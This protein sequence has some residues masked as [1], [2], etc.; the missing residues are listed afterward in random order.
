[1]VVADA[2]QRARVIWQCCRDR[3]CPGCQGRRGAEVAAKVSTLISRWPSCRMITLTKKHTGQTLPTMIDELAEAFKAL[4]RTE[5]WKSAVRGGVYVYEV[6]RGA[7]GDAWHAH[8][9][10]LVTGGFVAQK[11]LSEA[12]LSCTGDS[13]I[14]HIKYVHNRESGASY[15][16]RYLG[17]PTGLES[18]DAEEIVEYAVAVHRRRL[19]HTF[20]CVHRAGQTP[21]DEAQGAKAVE[22]V[23]SVADLQRAGEGG[24]AEAAW[25]FERLRLAFLLPHKERAQVSDDDLKRV[26]SIGRRVYGVVHELPG[27]D[28]ATPAPPEV[29]KP[30]PPRAPPLLFE[31]AHDA[32]RLS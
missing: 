8:V 32:R 19:I 9:H 24:D 18:W 6:T 26:A 21:I 3:L 20:G 11:A 30:R 23:C 31:D 12:W 15:V 5:L 4:R 16:A 29:P 7:K 28:D 14:V 10:V 1:M 17:K 13:P 25:A 22:H 2:K 27:I